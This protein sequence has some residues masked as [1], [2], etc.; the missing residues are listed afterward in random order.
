MNDELLVTEAH[1]IKHACKE[2][3]RVGFCVM[4]PQ[5]EAIEKLTAGTQLHDEVD[6]PPKAFLGVPIL[7]EGL[8]RCSYPFC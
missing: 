5:Q 2:S 6:V 7:F 8:L 3:A 1:S 4:R